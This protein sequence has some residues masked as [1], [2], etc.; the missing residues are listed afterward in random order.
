MAQHLK[1]FL[2]DP[3]DD[4]KEL[5]RKLYWAV[6]ST[7]PLDRDRK[8]STFTWAADLAEKVLDRVENAPPPAI[9]PKDTGGKRLAMGRKDRYAAL[10]GGG[11]AGSLDRAAAAVPPSRSV[12]SKVAPQPYLTPQQL[13]V[14]KGTQA[15]LK[16][17]AILYMRDGA[18]RIG[19]N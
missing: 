4:H 8:K 2:S 5:T 17:A 7:I 14:F 12:R 11:A 16:A 15:R 10:A 18:T 3:N 6:S 1:G 9:R 13:E 19:L